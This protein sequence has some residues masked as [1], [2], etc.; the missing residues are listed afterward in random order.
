[1]NASLMTLFRAGLPLLVLG[2]FSGCANRLEM[3]VHVYNPVAR[4]EEL[5]Q[6]VEKK[7]ATLEQQRLCEE[8]GRILAQPVAETYNLAWHGRIAAII[9]AHQTVATQLSEAAREIVDRMFLNPDRS[10]QAAAE[11]ELK[12]ALEGCARAE[13]DMERANKEIAALEA[14]RGAGPETRTNTDSLAS[15]RADLTAKETAAQKTREVVEQRR[16]EKDEIEAKLQESKATLGASLTTYANA[17]SS[18]VKESRRSFDQIYATFLRD[19]SP[20]RGDVLAFHTGQLLED[21]IVKFWSASDF[22]MILQGPNDPPDRPVSAFDFAPPG[23]ALDLPDVLKSLYGDRDRGS[24]AKFAARAVA[25]SRALAD[26]VTRAA[27]GRDGIVRNEVF[28]ESVTHPLVTFAQR[29]PDGWHRKVAS[30][31]M[32]SNVKSSVVVVRDTPSSYSI[33]S[34]DG[35]AGATVSEGLRATTNTALIALEAARMMSGAPVPVPQ[36]KSDGPAALETTPVAPAI[37]TETFR[38]IARDRAKQA[39][40]LLKETPSTQAAREEWGKKVR[41]LIF[42]TPFLPDK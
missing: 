37:P 11:K 16:R 27:S 32:E 18:P 12:E 1:M 13:A 24:P 19:Q 22:P 21:F 39:D 35:E 28:E 5:R 36:G 25:A 4:H 33:V 8:L 26:N 14:R 40:L 6:L 42:Y 7:R 23:W 34:Y 10:R 29:D 3:Q 9:D 20:Q 41:A 2:G 15:A 17:V 30:A 38:A 31:S